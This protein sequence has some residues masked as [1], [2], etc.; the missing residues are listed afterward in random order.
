MTTTAQSPMGTDRDT[1]R[2]PGD[3]LPV[4]PGPAEPRPPST[5]L[6]NRQKVA[7]VLAQL[8]PKRATPILREM[9]DSDAI[10]FTTEI[11][12]LPALDTDTVVGV[13]CELVARINVSSLVNQGGITLARQFL[14]EV[15]G[16]ARADEVLV[17]ME[18]KNAVGPLA[19]LASAD[20]R[21]VVAILAEQQPQ[22]V[23]VL[24]AHMR[25]EDAARIMAELPSDLRTKVTRRIAQLDR[26]DPAAVRQTTALIEAKLRSLHTPGALAAA[27]GASAVAEILNHSDRQTE[28]Q[29]LGELES[30]DSELVEQIRANLFTF[31]DVVALDARSL[32][33][34]LRRV[35]PATLATALEGGAT[36]HRCV[37]PCPRQPD[38]T[39]RPGARRGDRGARSGTEL[40]GGRG[41]GRDRSHGEGPRRARGHRHCS[42]RRGGAVTPQQHGRPTR[43]APG[44]GAGTGAASPSA[45]ARRTR[46]GRSTTPA[47]A[48]EARRPTRWRKRGRR[49][50]RPDTPTDGADAEE[51]AGD[52]EHDRI[53]RVD[54]AIAALASS[55][56]ALR[57]AYE[58]RCRELEGS[59]PRFAFE[60]LETLF[61]RESALAAEPGRDA[62]ARALA[63]DESSAAGDRPPAPRGCR[64][65]G[66]WPTS[67]PSR[68]A[69][70]RRRSA[71]EPGGALVE[72]GSTTIDSQLSPA[73]E[74]VRAV[75]VGTTGADASGDQ[76]ARAAVRTGPFRS[77]PEA[78][79]AAWTRWWACPSR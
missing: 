52:V 59:L 15:V 16:Q 25:P 63:L 26:V 24:L 66:T 10:A 46:G 36:R 51:A 23:A 47:C 57:S 17:Q 62:V 9:S 42:E 37:G 44:R 21:Q 29:I 41:P 54:R 72:I 38:R 12:N 56:D 73:L 77:P 45:A 78:A 27:G 19:A 8:G 32:Q 2:P 39:R 49:A 70:G 71:V 20:P 18:N 28:R 79:M 4:A 40:T 7:V 30:E 3:P 60:L 76:R 55:T 31:D 34:I 58:K 14:Q 69:D 74:R 67:A 43:R 65:S 1:D 35:P 75:L 68:S 50:T 5:Q 13:L 33:H 11:A 53:A 6:T 64:H 48:R 22:T 61:G